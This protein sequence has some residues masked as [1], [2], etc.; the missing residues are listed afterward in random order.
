MTTFPGTHV[1]AL[2]YYQKTLERLT[3]KYPNLASNDYK[4]WAQPREFASPPR[5]TCFQFSTNSTTPEAPAKTLFNGLDELKRFLNQ[6]PIANTSSSPI[7]RIFLLEG[8]HPSY[9]A[10]LDRELKIDPRVWFRHQRVAVWEKTIFNAGNSPRLPSVLA[11]EGSF[12]LDYCQLMHLNLVS[13][14]FTL[15]CAENERHIASSR[16]GGV[17]GREFDGIGMVHR[18]ASFWSQ[19]LDNGGWTG[20]LDLTLL[21][22]G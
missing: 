3:A 8:L 5:L 6:P 15:R 19:K 21:G 14:D 17:G 20:K 11:E 2:D 9:V 7:R 22:K 13:Q 10:E 1:A 12:C 18:K 16:Q 4:L